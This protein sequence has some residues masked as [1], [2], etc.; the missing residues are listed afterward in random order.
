MCGPP[1]RKFGDLVA[2]RAEE[3]KGEERGGLGLLIGMA[4]GRNGQALIG[5]KHRENS[6]HGRN[7]GVITG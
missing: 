3:R 5:I 1:M 2:S 6:L 4:R 7:S